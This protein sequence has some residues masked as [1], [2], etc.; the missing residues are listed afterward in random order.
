[1]RIAWIGVG[2]MGAPMV[3]RLI[4]D[5]HQITVYN[6]TP[7]KARELI[8]QGA[9]FAETPCEAVKDA[10]LIFC[11]VTDDTASE[12]VYEGKNGLLPAVKDKSII[13]ECSTISIDRCRKLRDLIR[14]RTQSNFLT[15]PLI[16]TPNE[17][18]SGEL[19]LLVGGN[20][21]ILEQLR[22]ILMAI[23]K[24]IILVGDELQAMAL[25]L[26]LTGSVVIQMLLQEELL[27]FL[28]KYGLKPEMISL[29]NGLPFT[30]AISEIISK[31]KQGDDF[32]KLF[33][34]TLV[35]KDLQY[36]AKSIIN[37][38]RD[39]LLATVKDVYAHIDI[40]SKGFVT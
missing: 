39:S 37:D 7:I 11:T 33:P 18:K 5:T 20:V 23:G 2:N 6:R 4:D 32:D 12:A 10:D 17:A 3:K 13:I 22:P 19:L 16:G 21:G 24:D 25:K 40:N 26:A 30:S 15:M 8:E 36:L 34:I 27:S 35:H 14:G 31:M 1:M 9:A 29:F 38:R 28:K